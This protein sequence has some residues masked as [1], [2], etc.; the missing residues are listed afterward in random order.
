MHTSLNRGKKADLE[1]N[2]HYYKKQF[3]F[4]E[5]SANKIFKQTYGTITIERVIRF[6]V[7]IKKLNHKKI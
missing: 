3:T 7:F 1:K 4:T 2:N 6:M 5:M